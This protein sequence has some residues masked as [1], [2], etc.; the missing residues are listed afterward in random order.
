MRERERAH[1]D[2]CSA[3]VFPQSHAC[4]CAQV[5]LRELYLE[6]NELSSLPESLG[7]L[8]SLM[9]LGFPGGFGFYFGIAFFYSGISFFLALAAVL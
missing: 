4:C 5:Q 2:T 3:S 7:E 1:L 8:S 6:N 9:H